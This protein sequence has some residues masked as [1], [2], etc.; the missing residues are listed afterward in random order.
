MLS[1][2]ALYGDSIDK[3]RCSGDTSAATFPPESASSFLQPGGAPSKPDSFLS[4]AP[5]LEKY[6]QS[7]TFGE[8]KKKSKSPC[9]L[10]DLG[11]KEKKREPAAILFGRRAFNAIP[12]VI[13]IVTDTTMRV[14]GARAVVA[15]V[16]GQCPRV[17]SVSR[18]RMS[19]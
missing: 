4:E 11:E 14:H 1:E 3:S 18:L 9:F 10:K 6:N 12:Q 5:A 17:I 13:G 2:N 19:A 15:D 16:G 7:N 8:W